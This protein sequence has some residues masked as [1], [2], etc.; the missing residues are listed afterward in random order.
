MSVVFSDETRDMTYPDLA[1]TPFVGFSGEITWPLRQILLWDPQETKDACSESSVVYRP[2]M[3]KF[4]T[5]AGVATIKSERAKSLEIQM[6]RKA[7]IP[8]P[9]PVES[10]K[11]K[12]KKTSARKEQIHSRISSK[13]SGSRDNEMKKQ[14][15]ELPTLTAPIKGETL[16]MYICAT[17]EALSTVLLTERDD[18]QIPIYFV[19]KA[20]QLPEINY[21]LKLPVEEKDCNE[22]VA[23]SKKKAKEVWRLFTDGS[24]NEGGFKAEVLPRKSI[25]GKE[26]V[27]IVKENGSTWMTLITEYLEKGTL[28][29]E[30]GKESR[31]KAR[32]KLMHSGPRS[33]VTKAMQLGY[34]WPTMN[35][36]VRMVI[37]ACQERQ[38]HK[39]VPRLPKTKLKIITSPC[40][41]HKWGI[42][43]CDLFPEAA[44]EI[45]SDNGK[46]FRDDPFKTRSLGEGIKARLGMSSLRCSMVDK[47][48]N[49][50]GLLL[51]FDLL[52][53][54][55]ELAAIAEEKHKI[56]M[57]GHYNSKVQSTILKPVDMVATMKPPSKKIRES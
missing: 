3:I 32:A 18:K 10:V 31:L 2:C 30:K 39:S 20:L 55:M 52:E 21:T 56:K 36:N 9:K 43:I 29:E 23:T 17:E 12:E 8:P 4:S 6:V 34:Y 15:A 40:L 53:E 27:A 49:D 46:Q 44:G 5:R 25:E 11:T 42:D 37:R 41:F 48:K 24:S 47:N 33:M 13:A 45:I 50:E 35:T 26:I 22:E 51:N 57:E 54:K 14:V 7:V 38:V 28:L 16:I 19:G 1:A